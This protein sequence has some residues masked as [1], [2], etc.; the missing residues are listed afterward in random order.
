MKKVLAVLLMTLLMIAMVGCAQEE[1]KVV[2]ASKPF[3]ESYI[4]EE[5]IKL[6][7][8]DNTDI[9]VE[10]KT[11]IGGG[12]ANI[13]P[14]MIS[15]EIDIYPEYTG[16][17][18]LF[19]LKEE[20]ITDP[21]ELYKAVKASYAEEYNIAW[22]GLYGF[23]D[24]FAIALKEDL[25]ADLGIETYSDL[26]AASGDLNFG[27]EYDFF[28][29][30]DGYPGLADTYGFDFGETTEMDIALK[31]DA[32][33]QDEVDVIN[34]FSTDGRLE[35]HGLKVIQDDKNFFPSY[36]AATLVRQETLDKYPELE[37]ALAVLDGQITDEEMTRMNY[38]VDVENQDPKTVALE[39]LQSK[40]LHD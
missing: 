37:D 23:N 17:G 6:V 33:A 7:I 35:L 26:A 29:R 19:V 25:A 16:T 14:G 30:E 11:G 12:T 39:F 8:E 3:T 1:K 20:L 5:L 21:D 28:E 22:S 40:G 38:L 13:H 27:A 34:V 36:F 2:V 15:G 18:W 10:Q 24:T 9:I 4:L 31:Y 32:I